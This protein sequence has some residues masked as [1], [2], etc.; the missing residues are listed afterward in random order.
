MSMYHV[1]VTLRSGARVTG[2]LN[3]TSERHCIAQVR[4]TTEGRTARAVV[5]VRLH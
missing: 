3:A 5:A 2:V 4:N 1:T